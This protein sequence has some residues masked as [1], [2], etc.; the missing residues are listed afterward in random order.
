MNLREF[1]TELRQARLVQ[2]ER[3]V[4]PHL[5]MARVIRA[6]EERS[7]GTPVLFD[8]VAGHPGWRVVAGPCAARQNLGLALGVEADRL[9]FALARRL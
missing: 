7:P 4:S 2:V 9:L 5:E 3:P 1:I 6:L 8:R